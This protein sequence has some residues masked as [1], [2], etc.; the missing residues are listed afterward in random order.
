[1]LFKALRAIQA[2]ESCHVQLR[3]AL[4]L[5]FG[6]ARRH[7]IEQLSIR[8]N[9]RVSKQ[10]RNNRNR[11]VGHFIAAAASEEHPI[12]AASAAT[13]VDSLLQR[14]TLVLAGFLLEELPHIRL[15]LDAAGGHDI[16]IVVCHPDLLLQ[17][18]EHALAVGEPAW[19]QPM[20]PQWVDGGGWGRRR[21]I[22]F[23]GIG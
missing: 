14:P 6:C 19:D 9:N 7:F 10:T 5:I 21:V 11:A 3:P 4:N 12:T 8:I 1:M 20:P 17:P 16:V 18:V 22:L 15:T 13:A 2:G 23:S